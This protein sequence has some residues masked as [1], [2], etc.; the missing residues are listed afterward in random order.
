MVGPQKVA[1]REQGQRHGHAAIFG[2]RSL[3]RQE[4]TLDHLAFT[5]SRIVSR[6]PGAKSPFTWIP[7]S[8]FGNV[9]IVKLLRP[10]SVSVRR[11][12]ST[13]CGTGTNWSSSPNKNSDGTVSPRSATVGS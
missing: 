7:W 12:I 2:V 4:D 8:A 9:L 1:G 11:I 13:L 3:E 10:L 5:H 6:Y